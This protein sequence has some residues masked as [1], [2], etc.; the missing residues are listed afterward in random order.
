MVIIQETLE[1]EKEEGRIERGTALQTPRS[2]QREGQ[3]LFREPKLRFPCSLCWRLWW[4]SCA[5]H[6]IPWWE[7][8]PQPVEDPMPDQVHAQRRLWCYEKTMLEQAP[9]RTCGLMYLWPALA[10]C[11]WRTAP[12][13]NGLMLEQFVKNCSLWKYSE[14]LSH[15]GGTHSLEQGKG[16]NSP[17]TK[18]EGVEETTCDKL[19]AD[20]APCLPASLQGRRQ[21]I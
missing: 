19:T 6:E 8:H 15:V 7:I 20:P 18:E 5:T 13:G 14:K 4:G 17:P 21:R 11:S 9:G 16:V 3:E 1:P 12:S 10:V 2:V